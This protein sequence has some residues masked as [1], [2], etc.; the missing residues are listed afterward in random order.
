MLE[1]PDYIGLMVRKQIPGI[2]P[3]YLVAALMK[4][5][6]SF[7]RLALSPA[8]AWGLGQAMIGTWD[9]FGH[10]SP[11]DPECMIQFMVDYLEAIAYRLVPIG[12]ATC[13]WMA[14][15]YSAGPGRAYRAKD[16]MDTIDAYRKHA[17]RVEV[18]AREYCDMLPEFN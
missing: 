14:Y 18:T 1:V 10:G 13:F 16:R 4:W 3:W 12:R 9:E 2:V 17:I 7:N 11:T 6:S 8:G 15:G 5:E